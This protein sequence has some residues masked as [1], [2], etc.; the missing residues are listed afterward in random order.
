MGRCFWNFQFMPST[1][2]NNA[3]DY[4]D[5]NFIDLKSTEDP[6]LQR[7]IIYLKWMGSKGKCFNAIIL[8]K[9]YF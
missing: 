1:I 4:N 6:L 7:Q 9:K 5:D 2:L 3:I 8:D